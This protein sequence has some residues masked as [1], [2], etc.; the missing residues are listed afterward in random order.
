MIESTAP[1]SF[2]HRALNAAV[3]AI[4]IVTVFF[5]GFLAHGQQTLAPYYTSQANTNLYVKMGTG[6]P[7][8]TIAQATTKACTA[9][10]AFTVVLLPGANPADTI[11]GQTG[12]CNGVTIIDY[13]AAP[14]VTYKGSGGVYVTQGS[15]GGGPPTGAAGGDLNGSNYPNP[16]V[17]GLKGVPFCTGFA[18]TTGQA[19]VYTTGG[20]PS[21]CYAAATA[22][23]G[24]TQIVGGTGISVSPGGGTGVVTVTATGGGGGS[25]SCPIQDATH[26]CL[27]QAPFNVVGQS[28]INTTTVGT[29]APGTS[30]VVTSASSWAPNEGIYIAGAGAAGAPYTGKATVIAGTTFTLT[31]ATSTSVS[32]GALVK[33][34][35]T[36]G[37]LA[38]FAAIDALPAPYIGTL[39]APCSVSNVNGPLLQTSGA[40]AI[41]P[42][43]LQPNYGA[44]LDLIDIEGCGPTGGH[45]SISGWASDLMLGNIIGGFDSATGGGYAPFTNVDLIVNNMA[46]SLPNNS[47]AIGINA[48]AMLEATVTNSSV[49]FGGGSNPSN[50]T[51]AGITMPA[52]LNA[53]DLYLDKDTIAG[54]YNA[55]IGTEHTSIGRLYLENST[56]CLKIDNGTNTND[57]HGSIGYNGNGLHADH[58]WMGNC[59]NGV[60]GGSSVYGSVFTID[61]L[62]MEN[63]SG[64]GFLDPSGVLQGYAMVNIT[65]SRGSTTPCNAN[66]GAGVVTRVNI[67][68]S[69]C[70]PNSVPLTVGLVDNWAAHEGSGTSLANTGTD[71]TNLATFTN[72]TWATAAG[73]IGAQP[74]YNGSTTYTSP[75]SGASTGF[76]GSS[77]FTVCQWMNPSTVTGF[78]DQYNWENI[79]TTP[80]GYS[81]ELWGSSI[82]AGS[83]QVQ[84]YSDASHFIAMHTPGGA[85]LV[86]SASRV[87]VVNDGTKLAAGVHI[88]VN[89]ALQTGITVVSDTL[90]GQSI[91]STVPLQ[92]G[93]VSAGGLTFHG[94]IGK[95]SV[96][97]RAL[98]TGDVAVDYA[99]GSAAP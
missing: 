91:A 73:F 16:Q 44:Q 55:V 47:G 69:R 62:D 78:G 60:V 13:T 89:A 6:N 81:V 5:L 67:Q 23:G 49:V 58:I 98:S 43:P 2:L 7:Y 85:V 24:V 53:F 26:L 18:P 74:T 33:H 99:N 9:P 42:V 4:I 41:L 88:Y 32:A 86:G 54:A 37:W 77:G 70:Q 39:Y 61:H 57:A 27:V 68:Y 87:C 79:N 34:D 64:N 36:A 94:T 22:G 71:S 17:S 50:T 25:G 38:G 40:N 90:A 29:T 75:T 97:N 83:L 21:P 20:T 15:G 84:F 63:T 72:G 31:P 92:I 11:A 48:T 51:S 8:Q 35:D 19:V 45:G 76:D 28:G 56:N 93:G 1:K 14:A 95:T 66:P 10:T 46:M 80:S 59:V 65:D 3:W 52:I 82:S 30:V 12:V 96:W